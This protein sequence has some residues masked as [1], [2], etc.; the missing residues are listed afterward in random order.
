MRFLKKAIWG[1]IACI[2]AL[3]R[4]LLGSTTEKVISYSDLPVFAIPPKLCA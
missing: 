1:F 2:G 4:L 3:G